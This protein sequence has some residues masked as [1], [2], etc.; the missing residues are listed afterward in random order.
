MRS[1][2]TNGWDLWEER[3]RQGAQPKE[4]PGGRRCKKAVGLGSKLSK[5]PAV[6]KRGFPDASGLESCSD[7]TGP[8]VRP[9]LFC[10]CLRAGAAGLHWSRA[11]GGVG[12]T[13]GGGAPAAPPLG[14]AAL[15][16]R[17]GALLGVAGRARCAG[18]GRAHR[19]GVGPRAARAQVSPRVPGGSPGD[20]EDGGG[21]GG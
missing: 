18:R 7:S 1:S 13:C 3:S 16:P 14:G 8:R 12:L 6:L 11:V 10:S 2:Q 15:G 20:R 17:P 21:G 9:R 19:G 5:I 4:R